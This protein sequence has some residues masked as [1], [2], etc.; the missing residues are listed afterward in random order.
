[1]NAVNMNANESNTDEGNIYESIYLSIH[2]KPCVGS[3]LLFNVFGLVSRL[4]LQVRPQTSM[5]WLR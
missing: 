3:L 1:M 5:G 2:P 4:F